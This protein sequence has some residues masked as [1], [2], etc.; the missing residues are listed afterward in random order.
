MTLWVERFAL[1]LLMLVATTALGGLGVWLKLFFEHRATAQRDAASK[2]VV[3]PV[4]MQT[5]LNTHT[6]AMFAQYDR[7]LAQVGERVANFEITN[8]RLRGERDAARDARDIATDERDQLR[9]ENNRLR[10]EIADL[11][12]RVARLE[13]QQHVEEQ[14]VKEGN[15]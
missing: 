2:L 11:R 13:A 1:P 10:A 3:E 7:Q 8:E 12:A 4:A 5:L 15:V 14:G 9:R 6:A